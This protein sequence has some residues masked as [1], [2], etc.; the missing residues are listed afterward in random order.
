[1]RAKRSFRSALFGALAFAAGLAT[2]EAAASPALTGGFMLTGI[3]H[4]VTRLI[5]S[6]TTLSLA[7]TYNTGVLDG[8]GFLQIPKIWSLSLGSQPDDAN[9]RLPQYSNNRGGTLYTWIDASQTD[10]P[11]DRLNIQIRPNGG[12]APV[13]FE[14]DIATD[15]LGIPLRI[16]TYVDAN[17]TPTPNHATFNLKYGAASCSGDQRAFTIE[18]F[19]TGSVHGFGGLVCGT[20]NCEPPPSVTQLAALVIRFNCGDTLHGVLRYDDTGITQTETGKIYGDVWEDDEADGIQAGNGNNPPDKNLAGVQINLLKNGEVIDSTLSSDRN[21]KFEVATGDYQIEVVPPPDHTPTLRDIG[22]DES[23]DSDVASATGR[24]DP[25][26]VTAVLNESFTVGLARPPRATLPLAS[27]ALQPLIPGTRVTYLHMSDDPETVATDTVLP[28]ATRIDRGTGRRILDSVGNTFVL[29]ND[30]RGLRL[31]R[32]SL[33]DRKSRKTTPVSFE[34]ALVLLPPR[35]NVGDH[36]STGKAVTRLA[37][38]TTTVVNYRYRSTF[39]ADT[40]NQLFRF[41]GYEIL[42]SDSRLKFNGKLGGTPFDSNTLSYETFALAAGVINSYTPEASEANRVLNIRNGL[43]NDADGDRSSDV[44]W[45]DPTTGDINLWD[46]NAALQVAAQASAESQFGPVATL[47]GGQT[48]FARGDFD[49]DG[50][51]DL[52]ARDP[53][54]GLV[55]MLN[56]KSPSPIY[57]H[58]ASFSPLAMI[59]VGVGDF[60]ADGTSELL[61]LEP[62]TGALSVWFMQAGVI[63]NVVALSQTAGAALALVAGE[64]VAAVGDL[65]ADGNSDLV[66]R[67]DAA[68]TTQIWLMTGTQRSAAKTLDNLSASWQLAAANDFDGNGRSDLLWVQP[69]SGVAGIWL[70]DGAEI[71]EREKFTGLALTN[72]VVDT[73][74]YN[75]DGAADI[76]WQDTQTKNVTAWLMRGTRRLSAATV[77]NDSDAQVVVLP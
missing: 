66:V 74:D 2:G 63:P 62:G 50:R 58:P 55:S 38:G 37:N 30:N 73:G 36:V 25:I 10:G 20:V 59:P 54:T 45:T 7:G 48:L 40:G 5:T 18:Q 52:A 53:V 9:S 42:V 76:L 11:F 51:M 14:L 32:A 43:G 68:G 44:V 12:D 23:R 27:T 75:A 71:V 15:Q 13:Y 22:T 8:G 77:A 60:N 6:S 24:S 56:S 57:L 70:M 72:K 16:G 65:N 41:G 3:T 34:P 61:W 49:G 67:N 1:M 39:A 64:R 31:H 46:I 35:V 69:N 47:V 28:G 33:Y 26:S 21:F 29:S 4:G 19:A 17:P